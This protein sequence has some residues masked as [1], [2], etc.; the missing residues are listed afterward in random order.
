[1]PRRAR[2]TLIYLVKKR[3]KEAVYKGEVY[4]FTAWRISL[5]AASAGCYLGAHGQQGYMSM[6]CRLLGMA[7][8]EQA[9]EKIM[10]AVNHC[11]HSR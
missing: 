1:M 10:L 3:N 7:L 6:E 8:T 4:R 11:E 2:E 5:L 9:L